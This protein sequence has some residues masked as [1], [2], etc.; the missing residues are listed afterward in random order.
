MTTNGTEMTGRNPGALRLE[1]VDYAKGFCIILIVMMM[2][3]PDGLTTRDTMRWASLAR[4][5]N[6]R[7]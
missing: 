4:W 6:G 3:R 1:W 2:V 7:G 5:R